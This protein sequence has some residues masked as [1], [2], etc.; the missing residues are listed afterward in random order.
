MQKLVVD[1]SAAVAVVA[2][3]KGVADARKLLARAVL[4]PLREVCL[5]DHF[6]F[7]DHRTGW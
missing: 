3:A 7:G 1:F 2:G 4:D 5:D 6:T